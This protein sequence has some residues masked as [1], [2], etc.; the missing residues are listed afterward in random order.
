MAKTQSGKRPYEGTKVPIPKSRMDIEVV[1]SKH[2]VTAI[3][4]TTIDDASVLRFQFTHEGHSFYVRLVVDP[5]RQGAKYDCLKHRRSKDEHY[6]AEARRLNRV[7]Y[8]GVKSKLELVE[9]GL[10]TP[11]SVW[12]PQLETGDGR[13]VV[14]QLLE[15][16]ARLSTPKASVAELLAL[17]AEAP[18]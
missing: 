3:Q 1:L 13:T 15:H 18:R 6:A 11:F 10:E 14:E 8:F 9:A 7:L 5:R 12:L 2:G 4:W 16:R 17:P